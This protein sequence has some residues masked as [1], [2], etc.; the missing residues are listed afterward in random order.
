MM[1]RLLFFI[2]LSILIITMQPINV[3][4]KES[5]C[6][7]K[8]LYLKSSRLVDLDEDYLKPTKKELKKAENLYKKIKSVKKNK[9]VIIANY[10]NKDYRIIEI[11][12]AK[13][14]PYTDLIVGT[15]YNDTYGDYLFITYKNCKKALNTNK[16]F[17]KKLKN[18]IKK[19]NINKNTTQKEAVIKI[20]DYL[21]SIIAY[22]EHIQS[23][24]IH[25]SSLGVL[26]TGKGVCHDY[27]VSFQ[28]L[29]QYCGIETGYIYDDVQFHAYNV[30]KIDSK[31]YY[32]DVCWNDCLHNNKY[33]LLSKKDILKDHYITEVYYYCIP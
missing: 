18:I 25:D 21:C 6:S 14:F 31:K 16:M 9:N 1:K 30:V 15:G 17:D 3:V 19:L 10:T 27:A 5:K 7:M 20:N 32:L 22:D 24:N 8:P 28:Y 11:V 13:Y 26:K 2:L 29:A 12:D 33:L 4:A 23:R